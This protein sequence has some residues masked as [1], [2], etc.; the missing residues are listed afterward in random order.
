MLELIEEK[1]LNLGIKKFNAM[2]L[3]E[4]KNTEK[5]FLKNKYKLKMCL[6]EKILSN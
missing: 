4:N 2:I 6:F 5:F 3:V 1:A